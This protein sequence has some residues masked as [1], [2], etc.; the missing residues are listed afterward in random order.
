ME[1]NLNNQSSCLDLFETDNTL[2]KTKSKRIKKRKFNI[3]KLPTYFLIFCLTMV[4]FV[5]GIIASYDK[6]FS[7]ICNHYLISFDEISDIMRFGNVDNKFLNSHFGDSKEDVL[8]DN[9]GI[10]FQV[11]NNDYLRRHN[12]SLLGL[13]GN[14]LLTFENDKLMSA[15]FY[16]LENYK[17]LNIYIQDFEMIKSEFIKEFGEP[18]ENKEIWKDDTY[19]NNPEKCVEAI[20]LGHLR[21]LVTWETN[22][23][24]AFLYVEKSPNWGYPISISFGIEPKNSSNFSST[25]NDYLLMEGGIING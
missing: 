10:H 23:E 20:A 1:D 2:N 5:T 6:Y 19:K 16:S 17:D 14:Y 8:N 12:V 21:Y 13:R 22:S 11:V 9:A 25:N 3:D 4:V 15:S 7:P 18:T 24:V